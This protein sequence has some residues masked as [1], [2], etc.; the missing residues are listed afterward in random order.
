MPAVADLQHAELDLADEAATQAFGARLASYLEP[1]DV[2]ALEGDLGAGKSTLARALIRE[3]GVEGEIP[4]PTFTLIQQYDTPY[5][6]VA[7][8]D[9]YRIEDDSEIEE[10][11]LEDALDYG[12]L[13]V[14]WPGRLG[15]A[16]EP[17][18]VKGRLNLTLTLEDK[19]EDPAIEKRKLSAVG[20]GAWGPKL[21]RITQ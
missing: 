13:V 7:H 20:Y 5:L 4:S 6:M 2:I 17:G 19:G 9:L 14:E 11:G 15:R 18:R 1:G 21:A 3:L 8:V 10:L 16:F 12:A